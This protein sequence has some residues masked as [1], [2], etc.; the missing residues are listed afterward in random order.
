[1]TSFDARGQWRD[2][3]G[4][5]TEH[6]RVVVIVY[7]PD[8]GSDARIDAVR[9]LYKARFNQLSVLRVDGTACVGF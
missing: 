9:A 1:M 6:T 7:H 4:L 5:S 8:R 2:P 3:A